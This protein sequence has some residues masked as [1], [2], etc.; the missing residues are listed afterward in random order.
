MLKDFLKMEGVVALDKVQ[1]KGI[2][3]GKISNVCKVV[4][5]NNEGEA[6]IGH[7]T[8]PG[9][10]GTEISSSANDWCVQTVMNGYPQCTYDCEHDGYGV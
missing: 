1:Q 4:Y 7:Y 10:T 8:F 9:S 6:T 2:K 5:Y 3:G